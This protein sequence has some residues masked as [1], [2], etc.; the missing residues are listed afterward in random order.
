MDF[1]FYLAIF[2]RR[3]PYFLI[4][5]SLG[6]VIGLF[7][8]LTQKPV[9]VAQ[10]RLIVESQQIPDDLAA[11]TVR[12]DASEQLQ[13]IQQRIFTRDNLL[14][15]ADRLGVYDDVD[16]TDA[17]LRLDE[18]VDDLNER[19]NMDTSGGSMERGRST[20][21][22][23]TVSFDAPTPDMAA[24]V[25][26]EVVDLILQEN[27]KIRTTVSGQTLAFFAQETSQLEDELSVI[28]SEILAF[29]EANLD[30]LPDSLQFRRTQQAA[31]QERHLE[32]EREQTQLRD[33]RDR[34]IGLFE[35]T[36][37]VGLAG[38]TERTAAE[39][40]LQELQDEFDTASAVLS[41]ENPRVRVLAAQISALQR[42]VAAQQ[43]AT[44]LTALNE[45][46]TLLSPFQLQLADIEGQIAFLEEQKNLITTNLDALGESIAATP[47]NALTLASLEQ[48]FDNLRAQYDRAVS[49]LAAA[50]VGDTIESLAKGQ[51]IT[52]I[53]VAIS[54]T[55]PTRPNRKQIA[56]MGVAAGLGMGFGL[57]VLLELLNTAV[58]RPA[59]IVNGLQISPIMTMPYLRTRGQIWRRR[60]IILAALI[61]VLVGVP[62]ILW[63]ID[64]NIEPLQPIFDNLLLSLGLD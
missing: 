18:K 58:R 4:L 29:Q 42:N 33:R 14:D 61:A 11:S 6:T 37:E 59:D 30:A 8:A 63:Y 13:I 9:Y 54:P 35:Q 17:Q 48:D 27:I 43:A 51:R 50:E 3:F 41:S 36:G 5:L 57:I 49:N 64:T 34:M 62:A 55:T 21:I 31:A 19:I 39:I 52:V 16:E 1:K 20:A 44:S 15:I 23:V 46:G 12:T 10:A 2:W 45:D 22:I 25:A 40:Q 38:V 60:L 56:A 26:N 24:E 47:G 53:E 28:R 32:L 7:V